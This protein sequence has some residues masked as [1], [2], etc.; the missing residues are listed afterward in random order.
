MKKP[1]LYI[2]SAASMMALS[3]FTPNQF[4]PGP[5]LPNAQDE[6][7]AEEEPAGETPVL[8]TGEFEYTNEF[9]VETYYTDHAVGLLDMTGFV[10]RDYEWELPVEGQVLGYMDLDEDNN[11]AAYHLMLPTEPQG[12]F[13]DV[14]FDGQEETGLQIFTVAYSPNLTGSV[15]STGDD[16]SLGWPA[17]LASVTT[18]SEN[19]DEVTGGKL[20]IWAADADQEFPSG[21]GKDGLLFTEDDPVMNV[22]DGYSVVDLDARPFAVIRERNPEMRLYEPEDIKVKDVSELTYTEAFDA[23]VAFG[24]RTGWQ[25]KS[26][27]GTRCT[28]KSRRGWR[29]RSGR[30]TPTRSSWR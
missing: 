12:I 13:N 5:V 8:I 23:L 29:T 22:P 11:R 28:R 1:F 25:A 21:F 27:T 15:F 17:Y 16:R 7:G 3:A 24:R 6:P 30:A 4:Q 14:D 20:V 26:R 2:L 9:V 19:N 18:D 10:R